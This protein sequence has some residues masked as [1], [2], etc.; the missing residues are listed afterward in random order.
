MLLLLDAA[1]ISIGIVAVLVLIVIIWASRY[2]KVG[3]NEVLVISGRR[4]RSRDARGNTIVR[5]FRMVKGGGT[6]VYPVIEKVDILSLEL[7]TIDVKTPEVYTKLGVPVLVD[8]VAQIK[9]K[10]DDVSISVASEQYLSKGKQ[11]ITRIALQ[12]LEGH[13]RAILGT[14]TVEEIYQ[15]RDAF[16]GKVQEVAGGDMASMGLH[17]VSF[18][19]RDIRDDQGYLEALGK[20][21][22]AAVKRDAVIGQAEADRDALIKSAQANQ[23]GQIAKLEA[24]TKVAEA[25][26]DYEMRLAEY[27]ASM[28]QRKAEADLA[29]DL[30]RFKTGQSVKKEEIAVEVISK[31]EMIKVQEQEI[32]RREKELDASVVKPAEAERTRI[33]ALAEAEKFKLLTEAEGAAQATRAKGTA[34]ADVVKAKGF[35]EAEAS[36]ARGLAQAEVIRAQGESEAAA[37]AAKADSWRQYSEAA[38]IQ[39]LVDVLPELAKNIAEPLS[40]TEKI[41]II[42]SGGEGGGASKVTRDVADIVAQLPPVLESLSGIQLKEL[43]SRIPGLRGVVAGGSEGEK[44]KG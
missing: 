30:Q 31:A 9:V 18:T 23:T 29:Y 4:H 14:L 15:N 19:I 40:K 3:P 5:G 38:V 24:D 34:E 26:R 25:N 39:M 16:A 42:N 1:T 17:I 37:M 27:Q 10:G 22:I 28:N 41:V 43:V 21:R 6:F 32:L 36:K 2:T 20:P 13:L 33:R 7:L 8:G 44:K 35:G 11:E 12:T